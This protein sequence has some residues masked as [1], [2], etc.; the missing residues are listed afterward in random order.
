ME[1]TSLKCF[2]VKEC[3]ESDLD[4]RINARDEKVEA[5]IVPRSQQYFCSKY[6][7]VSSFPFTKGPSEVGF[8]TQ[9]Y[10]SELK[11]I[12]QGI[13]VIQGTLSVLSWSLKEVPLR[14]LLQSC[15]TQS[16]M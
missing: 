14:Q 5:F 15:K 13:V 3:F 10:S 11:F 4:Y 12:D 7:A 1:H 8:Q 2:D 16:C 6:H 9:V